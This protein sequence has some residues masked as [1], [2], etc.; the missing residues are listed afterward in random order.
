VG[1]RNQ[2]FALYAGTLLEES[3]TSTAILSAGSDGIDGNSLAAGGVVDEQT[4]Q[5]SPEMPVDAA[6]ALEVFDSGRFLERVGG[7]VITGATGNNLRDL[8]ILLSERQTG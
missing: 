7:A 2:H 3:D 1:G 8:R 6:R 4:L 5:R